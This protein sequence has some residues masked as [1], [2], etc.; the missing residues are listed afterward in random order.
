MEKMQYFLAI[1][2]PKIFPSDFL[3][4][5]L[6]FYESKKILLLDL[7][8]VFIFYLFNNIVASSLTHLTLLSGINLSEDIATYSHKLDM[9]LEEKSLM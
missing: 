4:Q 2:V 6:E 5:N 3:S 9:L 7:L 8:T 1:T